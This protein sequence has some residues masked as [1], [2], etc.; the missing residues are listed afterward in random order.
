MNYLF[1]KKK[2]VEGEAN[3]ILIPEPASVPSAHEISLLE[4]ETMQQFSALFSK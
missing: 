2:H 3:H 4:Q 1:K